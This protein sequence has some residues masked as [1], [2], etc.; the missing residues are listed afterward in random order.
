MNKK[1]LSKKNTDLEILDQE[2]NS[3]NSSQNYQDALSDDDMKSLWEHCINKED[4][5]S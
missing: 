4:S 3:E 1:D 5:S 2:I